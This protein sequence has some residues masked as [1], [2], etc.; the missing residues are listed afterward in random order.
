MSD[1]LRNLFPID[2]TFSEGEI[3]TA[4]KLTAAAKQ[5][6]RGLGIAEYAVGDVWNQSGDA[7][8]NTISDAR[9]MIPSLARYLGAPRNVSPFVPYLPNIE[10]YYHKVS[11]SDVGKYELR[12]PFPPANTAFS[13]TGINVPITRQANKYDVDS[14]GDWY[15]NTNTGQCYFYDDIESTWRLQ[16]VPTVLG[17]MGTSGTY[18]CIPDPDTDSSYAFQG[19]KVQYVN[20]LNDSQ[21]YYIYL[22]PRGPLNN[23]RIEQSP[24]D[25]IHTP[26]HSSNFQTNTVAGS[27]LFWQADS[28]AADTGSNAEHYRYLLP[29]LLTSY[30]SQGSVLP[31]GFLYLWD[32]TGTGTII[33]GVSFSAENAAVPKK[34]LLVASGGNLTSWLSTSQGQAAY[35][36]AALQS[37]SHT[38]TYYPSGG[39]RLITTGVS[40]SSRVDMLGK[41]LYD[42]DH[43]TSGE[44]GAGSAYSLISNRISHAALEGNILR[45]NSLIP[46]LAPSHYSSDDHP[47]YLERHGYNASRDKY[48]NSMLGQLNISSTYAG[49]GDYDNISGDSYA[50]SFGGGGVGPYM[51]WGFGDKKLLLGTPQVANISGQRIFNS[52]DVGKYLDVS[53]GSSSPGTVLSTGA[54]K[55]TSKTNWI[56][57]PLHFVA[58]P[59]SSAG[60]SFWHQST[61]AGLLKYT[62][63]VFPAYLNAY[64]SDWPQ[65]ATINDIQVYYRS[66]STNLS[67]EVY[68]TTLP[69]PL[70]PV[71]SWSGIYGPSVLPSHDPG[72][73]LILISTSSWNRVTDM[74]NLRFILTA[75]D[76]A[77]EVYPMARLYVTYT[78]VSPWQP[79]S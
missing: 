60:T 48:K 65:G 45:G 37:S 49:S 29:K 71:T 55:V 13:W 22:P 18:N 69:D 78:S 44:G 5:S 42:H 34:Y 8:L 50:L 43:G 64:I 35:P 59:S 20:G 53:L 31:A 23:R 30:W 70:S 58:I 54:Y 79:L 61:T 10:Y 33:D 4:S 9:L 11:A 15:I 28:V 39:L 6:R 40:L 52:N 2:V 73:A 21:G 17:D 47:Q 14:I 68:R 12:L 72:S 63:S 77:V 3:P 24:Q 75:S 66:A 46:E 27:R 74:L 19:L 32:P 25:D 67:L 7:L 57:V 1:R 56:T 41:R 38:A 51:Y 62:G 76:T 26:A 16:Y 36:T